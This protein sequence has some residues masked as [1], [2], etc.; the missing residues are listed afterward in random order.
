MS[1]STLAMNDIIQKR[2]MILFSAH[3]LSSKWW[4]MGAMRKTRF[5]RS[6]KLPTCKITE[7][8]SI[9]KIRPIR[10]SNTSLLPKIAR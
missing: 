7:T 2:I 1:A 5:P 10:M 8:V 3:F 9:T 6:L 4:C